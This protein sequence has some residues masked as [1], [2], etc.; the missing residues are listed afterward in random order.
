MLRLLYIAIFSLSIQANA[1]TQ[2]T[3]KQSADQLSA[4]LF[5]GKASTVKTKS[6]RPEEMAK[7][8]FL[9]NSGAEPENFVKDA[10]SFNSELSE[11]GVFKSSKLAI[12]LTKQEM[13][14]CA[15]EGL[16]DNEDTQIDENLTFEDEASTR[17]N[18]VAKRGVYFGY[19]ASA[20]GW[21]GM[22]ITVL[23]VI[24]TLAKEV[25]AVTLQC[26]AYRD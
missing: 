18:A 17:L 12:E 7:E 9:K 24:D 2:T 3:V 1:S 20:Q 25:H 19:D 8:Y 11:T 4:H 22:P 21:G 10:T 6:S 23:L 26:F 13:A 15:E 5:N 14:Y 16:A